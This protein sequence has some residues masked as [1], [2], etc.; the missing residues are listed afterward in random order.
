MPKEL[1][2]KTYYLY[3]SE[4]AYRGDYAQA[5]DLL[6]KAVVNEQ[7]AEYFLLWGKIYAQQ[8][9]YAEAIEQWQKALEI[10]PA[11]QKAEAA[12]KKAREIIGDPF[13]RRRFVYRLT[14]IVLVIVLAA[15]AYMNL[16]QKREQLSLQSKYYTLQKEQEEAIGE[17]LAIKLATDKNLKDWGIDAEFQAGMLKLTGNVPSFYCQEEIVKEVDEIVKKN[18]K[19]DISRIKITNQYVVLPG[20]NLKLIAQKVYGKEDRWREIYKANQD[21]LPNPSIIYPGITLDIL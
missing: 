7:K 9:K 10:D 5:L 6:R 21:K 1:I 2:A 19:V 15:S 14:V 17:I 20:D 13:K 12:I 8:K 18:T 3:A 16:Q 4:L 11:H